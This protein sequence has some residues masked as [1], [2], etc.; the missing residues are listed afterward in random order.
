MANFFTKPKASTSKASPAKATESPVAGPSKVQSDFAKTFKPFVLLKDHQLAPVNWFLAKANAGHEV[1]IIDEEDH[2]DDIHMQAPPVQVDVT[3]MNAKGIFCF[4]FLPRRAKLINVDPHP[5][6]DR[7]HSILSSLPPPARPRRGARSLKDSHAKTN[8]GLAVRDLMTQLS[9]AEIAG[10]VN[11]VRSLLS[12][13]TD[14][15]LFPAK[16]MI[17]HED[18]RPGYFGTWTRSSQNV[19][20]RTPF[21]KDVV[22]LDY[23]YDSGEDWEEEPNEDA[24]DVVADGEDDEGDADDQDSDMDDWLVDDDGDPGTPLEERMAS[25]LLPDI[26]LPAIPKRKAEDAEKKLAKKRKVVVPLVPF[27]KGPCWESSI[28]ECEYEPFRP[29]QMRLFNGVSSSQHIIHEE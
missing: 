18:A 27:A 10:D 6:L 17:F 23:G 14:R 12:K 22:E 5:N 2:D 1:I 25:P 13:L 16:V 15:T 28:G 20:P 3:G 8:G 26:P 24:D 4:F 29:Y 19:G 7:L 21:A 11:V 9:E